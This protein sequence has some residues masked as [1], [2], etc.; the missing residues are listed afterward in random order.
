MQV[1]SNCFK[2][3]ELKA[4]IKNFNN[5]GNCS[6]CNTNNTNL[7]D[8]EELLDFF[9]E[10]MDNFQLR[11]RGEALT[12][13]IQNDWSF[14]T[15]SKIATIILNHILPQLK[16]QIRTSQDLI[17]YNDDILE[18][19][20]HWEILKEE[21]KWEKRFITDT[22]Y[23]EDLGWDSFF[24][25][26]Y[27]LQTK[28]VLFRARVHHQ[29]G[30]GPYSCENMMSPSKGFVS[31]GRANP[32]GIPY[33]YLSDNAET[34]L[35]EVRASY[36]DELSIAYIHLK[37][38]HTNT[39][40]VDFTEETPLFQSG[41]INKTIKSSLLKKRISADLS[42]PMRRYDSELEY[43][44]TQFICE[45][46]HIITGAKG[47]RFKSSLHN[48]GKNIVIFDQDLMTCSK[49]DLKKIDKLELNATLI[50]DKD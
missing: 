41:S 22:K 38:E 35:Y 28:D 3:T 50:D 47:I 18:N 23:L 14:F 48:K 7:I 5:K 37:P 44:P 39:Y 6:V 4:F 45:Y 24:S 46:I 15:N 43:I 36:L 21:L 40:I 32:V 34:V 16:S 2:D 11:E 9:Q 8:T 49:V 20:N 25:S 29:S 17:D 1:C 19:I 42:K 13:K 10:L 26:Q 30:D 12:S 31:G 27:E 33:L